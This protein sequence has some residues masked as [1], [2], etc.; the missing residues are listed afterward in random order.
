MQNLWLQAGMVLIREL[1]HLQALRSAV[2]SAS[3]REI[4]IRTALDKLVEIMTE[5]GSRS[6]NISEL[7]TIFVPGLR[8]DWFD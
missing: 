4:A 3:S 8:T 2:L 7:S 1:V 6:P 5:F